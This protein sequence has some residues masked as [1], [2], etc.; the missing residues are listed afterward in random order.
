M[1]TASDSA[2]RKNSGKNH[3]ERKGKADGAV[4]KRSQN[5]WHRHTFRHLSGLQL[6]SQKRTQ[7]KHP[8]H[9]SDRRR[10]GLK[11]CI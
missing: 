6:V 4:R 1:L 3:K 8:C 9:L 2:A 7:R 11:M 5:H 10:D